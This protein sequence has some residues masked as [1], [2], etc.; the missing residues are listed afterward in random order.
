MILQRQRKLKLRSL[1]TLT[2]SLISYYIETERP[3]SSEQNSTPKELL[4]ESQFLTYIFFYKTSAIIFL[5]VHYIHV[6]L[7]QKKLSKFYFIQ[8]RIFHNGSTSHIIISWYFLK[9]SFLHRKT[10]QT[11]HL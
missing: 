2:F 7:I 10:L 6:K 8:I 1:H 4:F 9:H 5:E 11:V 3:I